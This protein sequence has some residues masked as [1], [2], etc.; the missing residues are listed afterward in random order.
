MS[1]MSTGKSIAYM[2]YTEVKRAMEQEAQMQ[3]AVARSASPY[4]LSPREISKASPQPDMNATRYS[5]PPGNFCRPNG[6]LV[7]VVI[8]PS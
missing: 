5:V 4:R 6:L 1:L 7:N 2:P 8:A 3:N